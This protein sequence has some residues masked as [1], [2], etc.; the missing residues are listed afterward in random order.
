MKWVLAL[1]ALTTP[2]FAEG[3]LE[4]RVVTFRVLTYDQAAN[5]LFA[6][7]GE[8][9][10]VGAGVEFGLQPE[11]AQNG[12]DVAPARV[13]IGPQRIEVQLQAGYGQFA[14]AAF[15][16]Y[17]LAFATDCALFEDV[18]IDLQATTIPLSPDDVW[19][20]GGAIY[21]NVGGLRYTP[22]TR[23]VLN[24]TVADCPLS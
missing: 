13:D 6:G 22:D 11:G 23:F 5:P 12:L 21:V 8:T 18:A 9:V 2:V 16:G 20:E 15:N 24:L 1:L 3:S 17:E 10:T 14:E 4:N 7:Q 19:A